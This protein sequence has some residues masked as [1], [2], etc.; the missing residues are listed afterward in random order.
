MIDREFAYL[1]DSLSQLS[2]D[3]N[4]RKNQKRN[5]YN[6]YH[7]SLLLLLSILIYLRKRK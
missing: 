7:L 4:R 1:S 2:A 5:D 3:G 6:Y